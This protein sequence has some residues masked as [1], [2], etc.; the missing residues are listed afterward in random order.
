[1]LFNSY[2][3]LFLFLPLT[4]AGFFLC[5]RSISAKAA[6][7]FLIAA[8]MFFYGWWNPIYL[9]LLAVIMIFN[10]G[11]GQ[12]LLANPRKWLL[13]LGISV[14]LAV[15]GYFKYANFLVE[16]YGALTG[17]HWTIGHIMLPLAISFFTFQ[18]IA[19]LVDSYKGLTRGYGFIEYSLFVAFF[20][21]LIAGPIVHYRE[22]LPQFRDEKTYKFS[23]ENLA[24]GLAIFALGLA[25][26]TVFADSIAVYADPLFTSAAAGAHPDF[27]TAWSGMLTYALQLY[28]DFSGYSDMA[29]GAA[30]LFG[31]RLPQNF[32][33]PYKS[34]SIVDFW[35]RW[36]MTL[37]RFL[38]EYLYISLG[39]N[40]KG[41]VRRQI[42]LMLTMLLGGLWHGAGWTFV[43]WGGLHGSYLVINHLWSGVRPKS[44]TDSRF[45]R[46]LAWAL[47]FTVVLL[48]WVPFRATSMAAT[49]AILAGL[50]GLN[51]LAVP[52]A[53]FARLGGL[54]TFLEAYGVTSSSVG[55]AAFI[56][57]WMWIALLLPIALF[58]PN[59]QSIMGGFRPTFDFEAK[60]RA[61]RLRWAPT[62]CWAMAFA[63]I[64]V[65][66]LLAVNRVS[67]F[68]YFQF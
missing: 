31:V 43:L 48:A 9:P 42:N 24:V 37:S 68:L 47:T 49:K 22:V 20:P 34:Q 15:L 62:Q 51:G 21:Q 66:G 7:L 59:T 25:K 6:N 13:A 12:R 30:R 29:I 63:L 44:W 17:T 28:F 14:D 54:A 11:V 32:N 41:P 1:M 27:L 10:Y 50:G 67:A 18:K 38:R 53:L 39:G 16:N 61:R 40:R 60:N 5:A 26:K 35:R 2:P 45:Y 46:G 64:S 58:A 52:G 4:V 65:A 56:A 19:F 3:F 33:S 8:S 36:H 23:S 55:G 57:V